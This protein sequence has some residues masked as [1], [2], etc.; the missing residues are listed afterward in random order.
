MKLTIFLSRSLLSCFCLTSWAVKSEGSVKERV[1]SS[2]ESFCLR[3]HR[4][5]SEEVR[6]NPDFAKTGLVMFVT[7][8]LKGIL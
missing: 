8:D 5:G 1:I 7:V 2:P 6:L 4:R 3:E